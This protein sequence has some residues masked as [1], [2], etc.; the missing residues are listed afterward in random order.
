MLAIVTQYILTRLEKVFYRLV[1]TTNFFF[2]PTWHHCRNIA[3]E[4][5]TNIEF[6]ANLP[7]YEEEKPYYLH[8]AADAAVTADE[9]K[10]TNMQ[11]AS[12]V[13][14]VHSMRRGVAMDPHMSL[15]TN[16]FCYSATSTIRPIIS[17]SMVWVSSGFLSTNR[18]EKNGCVV[19]SAQSL[20]AATTS[21]QAAIPWT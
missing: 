5:V 19:L 21:R 8:L 1:I 6:L 10:L 9:M 7:L 12:K 15:E 16:G 4:I 14:T 3:M 2:F 11:W 18:K 20:F 13:T 17:L